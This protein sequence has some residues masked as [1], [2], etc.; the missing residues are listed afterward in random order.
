MKA[1]SW[2]RATTPAHRQA[3]LKLSLARHSEQKPQMKKKLLSN[4]GGK[5][6][7]NPEEDRHANRS[8][9]S[10]FKPAESD[11]FQIGPHNWGR[12]KRPAGSLRSK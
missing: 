2:R 1:S 10:S 9:Q 6:M 7:T 12:I 4:M 3:A 5:K 11:Q 8:E